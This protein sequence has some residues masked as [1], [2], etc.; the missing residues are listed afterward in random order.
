MG[1]AEFTFAK[2]IDCLPPASVADNTYENDSSFS[3]KQPLCMM[4]V[5]LS[6]GALET[7]RQ[8]HFDART[9]H[10]DSRANRALST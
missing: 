2:I 4:R 3:Y 5:E 6:P 7:I 1:V 10:F 8:F 9:L